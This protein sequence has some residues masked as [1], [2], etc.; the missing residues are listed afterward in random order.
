MRSI[1]QQLKDASLLSFV[2]PVLF[3]ICVDYGEFSLMP[4]L[5]ASLIHVEPN[6]LLASNVFLTQK[7][8]KLASNQSLGKTQSHYDFVSRIL[9]LLIS[10][11]TYS[12]P[13]A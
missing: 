2:L 9:A 11:R 8:I 7:L 12:S 4:R 1:V 13:R 5:D 3:N 10:R 6:Q